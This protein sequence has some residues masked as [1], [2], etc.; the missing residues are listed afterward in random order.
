MQMAVAIVPNPLAERETGRLLPNPQ[1]QAPHDPPLIELWLHGRSEH[2]Q[3][4]Y[5]S[6]VDRFGKPIQ[7]PF[8]EVALSDLQAFAYSLEGL[9]PSSQSR[10]LSSIKSLLAFGHRIGYLRF[11]VGRVLKVPSVKNVLAES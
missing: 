6:D 7:K 10:A 9:A 4:A 5:R 1:P 2:T 11:D 3:R 8:A